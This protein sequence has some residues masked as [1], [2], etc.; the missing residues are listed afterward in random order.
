MKLH[1]KHKEFAVK[2]YAKFMKTTEVIDAF[3]EQFANDLPQPPPQPE[4]NSYEQEIESIDYQFNRDE[5]VAKN[6]VIVEQRYINTYGDQAHKKMEQDYQKLIED[7]QNDF[8]LK[9]RKDRVKLIDDLLYNHQLE[10]DSHYRKLKTEL[11][12]QLR[13]LN[14][15]HTQFPEKYRQLFNQT[16]SEFFQ[17]HRNDILSHHNNIRNELETIYGYVKDL[18]FQEKVPK[19]AIKHVNAAHNIL[20]TIATNNAALQQIKN[21]DN[22]KSENYSDI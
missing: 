9:W 4:I 7:L 8:D 15:T 14:I 1:E 22:Q 10:I 11:S 13:R 3:I 2:C 12:N 20:K 21:L 17:R 6:M 19:E 5:Y 18:I 16:R